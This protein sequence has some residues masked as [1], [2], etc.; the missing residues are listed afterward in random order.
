MV[1]RLVYRPALSVLDSCNCFLPEPRMNNLLF[2]NTIGS[3][4]RQLL[5]NQHINL[6]LEEGMNVT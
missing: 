3:Y 6:N 5:R 4:L 2:C 1:E